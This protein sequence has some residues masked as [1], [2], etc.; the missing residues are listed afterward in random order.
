M[1]TG[2]DRR[3][4]TRFLCETPILHNTSPPDFFYKGTMYNFS[5]NGLYFESN[6]DLLQGHEISISINKPLQKFSKKPHQYFDAK[7]IWCQKLLDSTYQVGYG[8]KLI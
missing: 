6:E 5:K 7:I 8:A 1:P 4:Y 2:I 3:E